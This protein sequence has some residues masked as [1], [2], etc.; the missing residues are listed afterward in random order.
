[1]KGTILGTA[2]LTLAWALPA[3]AARPGCDMAMAE[4]GIKSLS[5]HQ[6]Q[7]LRDGHGMGMARA[8]ELNGYPGP[9][10]VLELADE[11]DLSDGQRERS[12]ALFDA[13]QADARALG[14]QLVEEERRLDR[15]FAD[16]L[17]RVDSMRPILDRITSLRG[18]LRARH[19]ESHIAQRDLLDLDQ[20]AR[21]AE[22][23]AAMGGGGGGPMHGHGGPGM[24]HGGDAT[25]CGS[26]D[27]EAM[28]Q[29]HHGD[30]GSAR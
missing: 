16:G 24:H 10:H 27:D 8:A 14:S 17:A 12:Q 22:L 21:Y 28:H 26:G 18:S 6:L 9:K 25:A 23:R 19:L 11:L 7:G 15:L 3:T 29:R 2:L 20:I 4:S 30:P 5:A 1:M 13:M